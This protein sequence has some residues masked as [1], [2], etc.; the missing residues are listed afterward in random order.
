MN[1]YHLYEEIGQGKL[2]TVYKGRRRGTISYVSIKSVDKS[3]RNRV[4]NEVCISNELCEHAVSVPHHNGAHICQLLNWYETRNHLWTVSEYCAGGDLAR[5]L[6]EDGQLPESNVLDFSTQILAGLLAL[7]SAGI[8]FADMKPSN[9]LFVENG[10]IKLSGFSVSQR[11]VDLEV[12][13]KEGKQVARRGSPF[14]MAPELF[15]DHGFHSFASDIWGLG[16][17]IY[18]MIFGTTPFGHSRSFQELSKH[19]LDMRPVVLP[20]GGSVKL[21]SLLERMLTKDPRKRLGW[22]ALAT[23]PWWGPPNESWRQIIENS[24]IQTTQ[25]RLEKKFIDSFDSTNSGGSSRVVRE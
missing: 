19:V 3:K 14:Y 8:V 7:H 18:E 16:V 23:D 9:V 20:A 12:C 10:S 6:K 2:S 24:A 13:L 21:R 22:L 17:V 4:M 25:I 1:N 5:V 11:I 15:R